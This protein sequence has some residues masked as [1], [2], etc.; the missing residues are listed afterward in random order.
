M[1]HAS[2]DLCTFMDP[3]HIDTWPSNLL[4]PLEYQQIWHKKKREKPLWFVN[5]FACSWKLFY[6]HMNTLRVTDHTEKARWQT[7]PT[8]SHRSEAILDHPSPAELS[9][10]YSHIN[11][12]REC[13]ISTQ[14]SQPKFLIPNLREH[15][16]FFFL[17]LSFEVVSYT[18]II[19]IAIEISVTY[20]GSLAK[21]GLPVSM[22]PGSVQVQKRIIKQFEGTPKLHSFE[23]RKCSWRHLIF[24]SF[25]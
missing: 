3:A 15:N 12:S 25:G 11:G 1:N 20:Y 14:L 18:A 21:T 24:F 2:Q 6:H 4:W 13:S 10:S 16:E 9:G 22:L 7:A 5:S 19:T 17:L 8:T 23:T